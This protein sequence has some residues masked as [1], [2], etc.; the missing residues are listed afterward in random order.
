MKSV[1]SQYSA[2]SCCSVAFLVRYQTN[3]ACKILKTA[4][5][6]EQILGSS[7]LQQLTACLFL[8]SGIILSLP[9]TLCEQM[10]AAGSDVLANCLVRCFVL[11]R[12]WCRF[13]V[14]TSVIVKVCGFAQSLP[15]D[16]YNKPSASS[17]FDTHTEKRVRILS[18][19]SSLPQLPGPT[20]LW[21]LLGLSIQGVK[22]G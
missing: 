4:F 16:A 22:R 8:H 14:W 19:R 5:R 21:M 18:W 10:L 2:V 3:A 1:L 17:Q 7:D 9:S 11:A 20:S 13:S 6:W 15:V 12:C